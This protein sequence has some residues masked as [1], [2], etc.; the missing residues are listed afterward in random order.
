MVNEIYRMARHQ[1]SLQNLAIFTVGKICRLFWL[2]I[3][4]EHLYRRQATSY[5]TANAHT[6]ENSVGFVE[7]V[8]FQV[9]L[10]SDVCYDT[11][12]FYHRYRPVREC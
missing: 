4:V 7:G 8:K 9:T 2:Q 6:R 1:D 12:L 3:L 5:Q 11:C 10:L